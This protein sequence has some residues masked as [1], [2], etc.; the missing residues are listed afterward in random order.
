MK[1]IRRLTG[2]GKVFAVFF[3]LLLMINGC[4]LF[5]PGSSQLTV[6][7]YLALGDKSMTEAEYN[8][9]LDYYLNASDL[10]PENPEIY[11]KIGVV[12]G[13]LH[14]QE[15]PDQSIIRG[16]T[17]RLSRLEYREESNYNNALYYFR[18]AADLGHIPSRDIL[19]AMHDNIQ[20]LD[21]KY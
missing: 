3:Y 18:Q 19:R 11:Y 6:E 9:A 20:H 1:L 14:S 7:D 5:K 4:S 17:D 2:L 12:Y 15:D 10:E 16:K 13:T 21:V 8:Q